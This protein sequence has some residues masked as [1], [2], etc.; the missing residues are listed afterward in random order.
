M[1]TNGL[2]TVTENKLDPSDFVL[3]TEDFF[4]HCLYCLAY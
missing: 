4:Y 2:V 1:A 3:R